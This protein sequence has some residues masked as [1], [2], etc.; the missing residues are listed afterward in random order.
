MSNAASA[1]SSCMLE[2]TG[3][4]SLRRGPR[5]PETVQFSTELR[6]YLDFTGQS[7]GYADYNGWRCDVGYTVVDSLSGVA[8]SPPDTRVTSGGIRQVIDAL[9]FECEVFSAERGE[10]SYLAEEEMRARIV[11]SIS[12]RKRP[13]IVGGLPECFFGGL[14][15]GYEQ[16]AETL[17]A[18]HFTPFD[19][20]ENPVPRLTPNRNWYGPATYMV[21]VGE[22]RATPGLSQIY[23]EGLRAGYERL[24]DGASLTTASHNDRFFDEWEGYFSRSEDECLEEAKRTG[25]LL[26]FSG[27]RPEDLLACIVDPLWCDYSERRYYAGH[28][29]RQAMA[30]FPELSEMLERIGRHFETVNRLMEQYVARTGHDPVDRDRLADPST[31]AEMG[32]L[33]RR[34]RHEEQAATALLKEV[35]DRL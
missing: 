34:S 24:T 6:S 7:Y 35:V 20:S 23:R 4:D 16:G 21:L 25:R 1:P 17:V 15:V 14:V 29:M 26:G 8:F 19:F 27:M 33:V 28:F 5:C 3:D 10:A 22:R 9:G 32:A 31:R 11:E 30:H 18:W 13:A 2:F 12:V